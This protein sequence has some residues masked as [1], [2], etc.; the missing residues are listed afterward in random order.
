M[1]SLITTYLK[2][3]VYLD[4]YSRQNHASRS[5]HDLSIILYNLLKMCTTTRLTYFPGYYR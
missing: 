4:N 1:V 3:K 2:N 5:K